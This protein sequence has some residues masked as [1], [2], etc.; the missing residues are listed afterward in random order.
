MTISKG[1]YAAGLS[2]IREDFSLDIES[3]I[4]H[5]E[6]L[7]KSGISGVFFFRKYWNESIAVS[8]RKKRINY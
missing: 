8:K 6:N 3:T 4:K 5:A 7:I 1:V 2:V